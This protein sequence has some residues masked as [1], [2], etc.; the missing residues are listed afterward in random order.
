MGP[1]NH[2]QPQTRW[3]AVL[4]KLAAHTVLKRL[5]GTSSGLQF[6]HTWLSQHYACCCI[7]ICIAF[8]SCTPANAVLLKGL[9]STWPARSPTPTMPDCEPPCMSAACASHITTGNP[10]LV[11]C[12]CCNRGQSPNAASKDT[13][14]PSASYGGQCASHETMQHM[15]V[16]PLSH[17]SAG[18]WRQPTIPVKTGLC[19]RLLYVHKQAGCYSN[20]H[21]IMPAHATAAQANRPWP[22]PRLPRAQYCPATAAQ[23]KPPKAPDAP[24]AAECRTPDS[25]GVGRRSTAVHHHTL[26]VALGMAAT[27]NPRA[28]PALLYRAYKLTADAKQP[29]C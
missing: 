11:C 8:L 13:C 15:P 27:I 9:L 5:P 22:H 2:R 4:F 6:S 16:V 17:S 18:H 23:E 28:P 25:A 26:A 10:R 14:R 3:G 29:L 24:T 21:C 12:I 20:H 1:H 19:Y 7:H